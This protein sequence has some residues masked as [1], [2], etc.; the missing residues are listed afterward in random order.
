MKSRLTQYL[1]E[2]LCKGCCKQFCTKKCPYKDDK[3]KEAAKKL[4]EELGIVSLYESNSALQTARLLNEKP[5]TPIRFNNQLVMDIIEM[6]GEKLHSQGESSKLSQDLFKA[7]CLERYGTTNTLSKGAPGY[8]KRNETV[9]EKYGVENVFQLKDVKEKSKQTLIEHYGYE[10]NQAIPE[11]QAKTKATMLKK[12]GSHTFNTIESRKKC[13]EKLK[14][15]GQIISKQDIIV[16]EYLKEENI[17][18]EIEKVFSKEFDG[19]QRWAIA[20]IVIG[21]VVFEIQGTYWHADPRFYKENDVIERVHKTAKEIWE[22]DTERKNFLET[23]GLSVI[24]LWQYDIE[25]NFD[26]VKKTIKEA[27]NNAR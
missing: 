14:Q 15:L 22:H 16:Q 11:V 13:F 4:N 27:L 5:N 3:Q 24:Y 23:F 1:K 6:C 10:Y 12:F 8:N 2:T 20:D 7:T 19:K 25:N 9:K 26:F 21:N 18:F 17:A